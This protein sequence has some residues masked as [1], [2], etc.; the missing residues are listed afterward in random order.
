[1]KF[2]SRIVGLPNEQIV[3][4]D[5]S[6]FANGN[7][8]T[9]PPAYPIK[10]SPAPS[11]QRYSPW[12]GEDKPAQLGP[13]EYF[14]LGDFTEI[15]ADSRSWSQGAPNHPPYALPASYIDG[16]VTHIYWPLSRCRILR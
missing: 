8:Q 7:Q 5:G 4:R 12:G 15:S 3:I 6:V 16:V 2:V 13:D 11:A 10:Y 14:I 9:P 1:M